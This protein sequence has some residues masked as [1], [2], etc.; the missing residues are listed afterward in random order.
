MPLLLRCML[1]FADVVKTAF[2]M[3]LRLAGCETHSASMDS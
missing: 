3:W 1:L 2:L